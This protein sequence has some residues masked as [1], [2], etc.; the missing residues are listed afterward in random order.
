MGSGLSQR[1]VPALWGEAVV[2]TVFA[3]DSAWKE[4]KAGRDFFFFNT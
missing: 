4:S 1:P 2:L 3:H